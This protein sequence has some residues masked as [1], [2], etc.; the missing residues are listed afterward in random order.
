MNMAAMLHGSASNLKTCVPFGGGGTYPSTAPDVFSLSCDAGSR[1]WPGRAWSD[2][3]VYGPFI[4]PSKR[5]CRILSILVH[6]P[7]SSPPR[8][9]QALRWL[10]PHM[11]H[12]CTSYVPPMYLAFTSHALGLYLPRTSHVPGFARLRPPFLH[13]SFFLLPSPQCGFGRLCPAIL[14]SSFC[15]LPSPRGGFAVALGSHWGRTGVALGWL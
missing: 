6:N 11:Y 1:R 8:F 15:N 12:A 13:S 14:H 7:P 3:V 4:G 10:V 5:L 9:P 2:L